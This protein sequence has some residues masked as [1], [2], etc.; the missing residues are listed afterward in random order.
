[1]DCDLL[2]SED[3]T[4]TPKEHPPSDL[5]I[6][7][8]WDVNQIGSIGQVKG[9]KRSRKKGTRGRNKQKSKDAESTQN[10]FS[11]SDHTRDMIMRLIDLF[12]A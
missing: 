2:W 5:S 1:V 11:E 3:M 4:N 6:M 10:E 8:D 7:V 12:R 9:M